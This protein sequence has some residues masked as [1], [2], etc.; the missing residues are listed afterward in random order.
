MAIAIIQTVSVYAA[1][2]A[3]LCLY[4]L[5]RLERAILVQEHTENGKRAWPS[6][7]PSGSLSICP[8]CKYE[9]G[10][11][12]GFMINFPHQGIR[13]RHCIM[14]YAKWIRSNIPE[15][16]MDGSHPKKPAEQFTFTYSSESATK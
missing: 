4:R 14:C 13:S 7:T 1:I 6:V 2:V 15:L 12:E 5:F 8:V 10:P 11:L 3:S 16:P 9:H